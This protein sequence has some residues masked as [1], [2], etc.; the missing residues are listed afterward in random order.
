MNEEPVCISDLVFQNKSDQK[1][2]ILK[3]VDSMKN[4][5]SSNSSESDNYSKTIDDLTD[6]EI[7][8]KLQ[9]HIDVKSDLIRDKLQFVSLKYDIVKNLFNYYSL[10]IL[11]V[12]ALIT[13]NDAFKLSMI[14]FI[15]NNLT[16]INSNNIEFSLNILS[17]LMG[18]Y[19]TI[20][21]SLIR[22][23]NYR[24][25][26]EKLKEMQDKLIHFKALYNR[27]YAVLKL[28]KNEEKTLRANIKEPISW[29]LKE[30]S[31][32]ENM[33]SLFENID[34]NDSEIVKIQKTINKRI[35]IFGIA[36][37]IE[38]KKEVL[39]EAEKIYDVEEVIPSIYLATELSRS[40][41]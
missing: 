26:M 8:K 33:L 7:R 11:V 20:I 2:P 17:L 21:A 25:K 23:R 27:E 9:K 4:I 24:E 34:N 41:I 18:T 10:N 31:A 39:S 5:E 1:K 38:E 40:K 35:Y 32:A 28:N 3:K 15:K 13:L 37:D 16:N 12:S 30:K 36:M 19:M 29:I 14:Q 22:F 6:H